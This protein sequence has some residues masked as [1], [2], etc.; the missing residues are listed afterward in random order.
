MQDY[1]NSGVYK[2]GFATTQEQYDEKVIPVFASLNKLEKILH[3]NG[4]P[5][6]LGQDLTELDIRLYATV[7]RFDVSKNS[8]PSF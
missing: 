7:V 3:E 1:L 8:V 5:F 6:L 2:A 4:G